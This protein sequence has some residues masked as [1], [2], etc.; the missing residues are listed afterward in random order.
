MFHKIQNPLTKK[1][2][3]IQSKTGK[4]I[5]KNYLL[6]LSQGGYAAAAEDP[7]AQ[8]PVAAAA[9]DPVAQEPMDQD[10]TQLMSDATQ[11]MSD[12]IQDQTYQDIIIDVTNNLLESLKRLVTG[13]A[14][15]IHHMRRIPPRN[16]SPVQPPS[17][18]GDDDLNLPPNIRVTRTNYDVNMITE[19]QLNVIDT[20][21]TALNYYSQDIPEHPVAY[22]LIK[23]AMDNVKYFLK[24]SEYLQPV[25]NLELAEKKHIMASLMETSLE[26]TTELITEISTT[27]HNTLIETIETIVSDNGQGCDIFYEILKL[28]F[29]E[30]TPDYYAPYNPL[31]NNKLDELLSSHIPD[32]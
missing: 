6:I 11:F 8:E 12:T 7:V 23:H 19:L 30:F 1:W 2:I 31:L 14:P 9:E 18:P 27:D 17:S 26:I 32:Y 10:A 20:V 22:I 24:D 15:L 4:K 28:T 25:L 21:R 3:N 13:L 16:S 29:N 5:L